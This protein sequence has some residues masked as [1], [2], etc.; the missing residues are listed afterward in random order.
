MLYSVYSEKR[1]I[2][3]VGLK[4]NISI[5]VSKHWIDVLLSWDRSATRRGWNFHYLRKLCE[6]SFEKIQN[7]ELRTN[8]YPDRF[9][10]KV[11]KA[12]WRRSGWSDLVQ[13][14]GWKSKDIVIV[15]GPEMLMTERVQKTLFSILEKRHSLWSRRSSLLLLCRLVK[16]NM[17]L[18][19]RVLVM[20]CGCEI[21][22]R[23]LIS[24]KLNQE[25]SMLICRILEYIQSR[26]H[27]YAYSIHFH[28]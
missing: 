12:H 1:N 5:C 27:W 25:T 16:P 21:C 28:S 6:W 11:I 9:W 7:G 26:W 17:F 13:K 3:V 10:W 15:I 14:V 8:H 23:N 18:Q 24:T 2:N 20:L 19:H 4:L 22:S